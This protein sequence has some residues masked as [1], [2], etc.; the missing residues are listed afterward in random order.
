M[1][2][3]TVRKVRWVGRPIVLAT[4]GRYRSATCA[5]SGR[6]SRHPTGNTLQHDS[7]NTG[8][9][10]PWNDCCIHPR[11]TERV[12]AVVEALVERH[13]W[14]AL[15]IGC[16]PGYPVSGIGRWVDLLAH[17]WLHRIG[18][19]FYMWRDSASHAFPGRQ[20]SPQTSWYVAAEL[21]EI[22]TAETSLGV[23]F[24]VTSL[25]TAGEFRL[26]WYEQ[27]GRLFEAAQ[28]DYVESERFLAD[29]L[30]AAETDGVLGP[31]LLVWVPGCLHCFLRDIERWHELS[32]GLAETC[33]DLGL[34]YVDEIL[35][36]L[37]QVM[38]AAEAPPPR[39]SALTFLCW[40]SRSC[41]PGP[42]HTY[43]GGTARR[44][45]VA[46][47]WWPPWCG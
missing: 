33:A 6:P 20:E 23:A 18:P 35:D 40:R 31:V 30:D 1:Q 14:D 36:D 39:R 12:Q 22:H 27:M 45:A 47:L 37:A 4:R 24:G 13:G 44:S 11:L 5:L 19:V 28:N 2:Q 15:V 43:P 10:E 38:P 3:N 8:S 34:E 29:V 9:Q 7:G 17:K 25:P 41:G 21:T 26:W 32:S 42:Q 46:L 16:I